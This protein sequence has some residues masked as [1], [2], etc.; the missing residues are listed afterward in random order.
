[1]VIESY[2]LGYTKLESV[3]VEN[4]EREVRLY[5]VGKIGINSYG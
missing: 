5:K 3:R 4:D 2:P 1:M